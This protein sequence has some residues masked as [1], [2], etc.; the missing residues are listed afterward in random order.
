MFSIHESELPGIGQKFQII[1]RSGDKLVIIIHDDG[2][3]EMYHF[4]HDDPE[5]SISMISLD[6]NEA[7]QVAAIL[8]GIIYKPKS[9]ENI[10]VALDDMVIEWYKIEPGLPCIG[11]TIGEAQVRKTTGATIIAII[12]KDHSK[13]INP[14][15]EH[16]INEGAT[17]VVIGEKEQIKACK[18]LIKSGSV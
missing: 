15:P 12:E 18:K 17:I 5:D 4:D 3:R 8:G 2:R 6:D 10:E 16:V 13:V 14:G 7:R 9:L 1:T 11:K